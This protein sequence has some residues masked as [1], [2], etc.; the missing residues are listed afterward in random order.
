MTVVRGRA[1]FTIDINFIDWLRHVC[2]AR[3]YDHLRL[4]PVSEVEQT[5]MIGSAGGASGNVVQFLPPVSC[6]NT[7]GHGLLNQMNKLSEDQREVALLRFCFRMTATEIA[8]FLDMNTGVASRLQ[9]EASDILRAGM[10]E[11]V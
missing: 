7:D 11:S 9:R 6:G 10:L 4:H 1:R 5:A 2:W 8:E 3:L